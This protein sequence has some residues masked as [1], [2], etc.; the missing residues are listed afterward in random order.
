MAKLVTVLDNNDPLNNVISELSLDVTDIFYIY[1]HHIDKAVLNNIDKVIKKYKKVKTH[2]LQ[3]K[4][5]GKEILK[6]LKS[7]KKVIAD[8]G[9]AKYL[10]LLLFELAY[11]N[12]NQ[13]IYY[14]DEENVIKDYISHKVYKSKVFK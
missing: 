13:L 2:F 14:D 4:D 11:K 6:I 7:D 8:V 10:S 5:D 1:H 3:L 12:G 9:G